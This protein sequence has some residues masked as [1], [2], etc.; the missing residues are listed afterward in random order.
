MNALDLTRTTAE[1]NQLA[2]LVEEI[3]ARLQAGQQCDVDEYA[4]RHPEYA[5]RLR[6]WMTVM[7]AMAD[8]GHSL[9]S[10]TQGEESGCSPCIFL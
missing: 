2:E 4:A 5:D 10:G 9:H 7:S 8:L 1:D 6:D 3:T